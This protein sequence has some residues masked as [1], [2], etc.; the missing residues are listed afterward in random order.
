MYTKKN[1]IIALAIELSPG[2][3]EQS[4][5]SVCPPLK[6]FISHV[7]DTVGTISLFPRH[8]ENMEWVCY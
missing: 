1:K 3:K 5:G 2:I 7:H 8:R 6:V 4:S